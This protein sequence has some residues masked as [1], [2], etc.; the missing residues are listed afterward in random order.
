MLANI[1]ELVNSTIKLLSFIAGDGNLIHSAL[2][3]G[4]RKTATNNFWAQNMTYF[5]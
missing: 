1:D 2:L 3:F 4:V 5:I